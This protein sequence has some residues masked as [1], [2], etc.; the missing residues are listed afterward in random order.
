MDTISLLLAGHYEK[1]M[2]CSVANIHH[3][4][5]FTHPQVSQLMMLCPYP[6]CSLLCFECIVLHGRA[7][8]SEFSELRE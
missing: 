8:M 3:T 2:Q 7:G 6:I 1:S 5:M 4:L